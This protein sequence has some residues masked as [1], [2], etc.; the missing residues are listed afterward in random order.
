MVT[1]ARHLARTK[2][3]DINVQ[4]VNEDLIK[5]YEF[6]DPDMGIL[7]GNIFSFCNYP[8]W[9]MRLTEFF[10]LKSCR[11]LSFSVFLDFLVKFSKCEQRLGK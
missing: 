5:Y 3:P 10:R 4:T 9:Q 2:N 6:P 8:P 1:L 11:D 7:C